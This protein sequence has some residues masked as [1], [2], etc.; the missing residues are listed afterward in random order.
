MGARDA[1]RLP[2]THR[3][4]P[5]PPRKNSRLQISNSQLLFQTPDPMFPPWDG[6]LHGGSKH[7]HVEL[8]GT[9]NHPRGSVELNRN[10]DNGHGV[11]SLLLGTLMS[12]QYSV[13]VNPQNL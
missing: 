12:A 4:A 5:G 3:T 9:V 1:A 10:N 11:P 13:L 8:T 7:R 2:T 6:V